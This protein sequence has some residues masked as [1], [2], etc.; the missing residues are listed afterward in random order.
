MYFKR[1]YECTVHMYVCIYV[2][3]YV[4]ELKRILA[5]GGRWYTMRCKLMAVHLTQKICKYMV[6]RCFT[7]TSRENMRLSRNVNSLQT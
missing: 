3:L 4:Y 5:T 6:C 2:C 7:V 1:A